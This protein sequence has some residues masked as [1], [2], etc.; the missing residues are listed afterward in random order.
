MNTTVGRH[1]TALNAYS[2]AIRIK[3]RFLAARYRMGL[4]LELMGRRGDAIKL[5]Q[6][7]LKIPHKGD[8]VHLSLAWALA[9]EKRFYEAVEVLNRAAVK[10]PGNPEIHYALGWAHQGLG[11]PKRA[12]QSYRETLRLDPEHSGARFK[13]RRAGG[14]PAAALLPDVPAHDPSIPVPILED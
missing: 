10:N 2:R 8:R 3:P 1:E 12:L 5:Y 13:I 14:S 11:H 9:D 4:L 6:S 7:A